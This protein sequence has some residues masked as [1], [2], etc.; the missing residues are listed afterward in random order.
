MA[1][2]RVPPI[3]RIR[4]FIGIFG[5]DACPPIGPSTS[6][7]VP[8]SSASDPGFRPP[9]LPGLHPLRPIEGRVAWVEPRSGETRGSVQGNVHPGFRLRLNARLQRYMPP[10]V[11]VD[12]FSSHVGRFGEQEVNGFGDVLGRA[13]AFER[14]VRNDALP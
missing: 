12:C 1:I 11:H 2:F 7:E 13:L 3:G 8:Q 4:R 5:K 14:R 9:A 10:T 6:A